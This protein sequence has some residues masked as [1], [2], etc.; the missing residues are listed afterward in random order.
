MRGLFVLMGVL[1]LSG[2]AK[3]ESRPPAPDVLL[4]TLDTLR[5]DWIHAYGFEQATS[6]SID[7]LA[8]RGVLFE[9]AIAAASLTAP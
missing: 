6:P 4:V 9:N 8:S 7:A 2:C 1:A 3:E 5:S